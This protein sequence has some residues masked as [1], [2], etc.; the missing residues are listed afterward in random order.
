[1]RLLVTGGRLYQDRNH[2]WSVL[3][4]LKP[5][6]S[7]L[8]VGDASG[9]DTMAADWARAT[10]TPYRVVNAPWGI[11]GNGAG[12]LRNAYMLDLRPD[13]VLA[14]DGGD[15]TKNCI[16]QAKDRHIPVMSA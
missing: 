14:F 13:F 3:S 11:L 5:H 7:F 6:I 12:H 9:V 16:K 2:V 1:M 8:I 10:L 4:R 15:G